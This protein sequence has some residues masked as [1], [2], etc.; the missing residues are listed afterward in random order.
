METGAAGREPVA[1]PARPIGAGGEAAAATRPTVAGIG[2]RSKPEGAARTDW[3]RRVLLSEHFVLYLTLV[4]FIALLPFLPALANP[5]N[6]S[7]TLSNVWPLLAVAV[8]QTFVLTIG[9]IDL[10]QGAVVGLTSVVAAMLLATTASPDVLAASPVWGTVITEEGG[11][12]AGHPYG[13]P[14]ALLAMFFTAVLIGLFNGVSVASFEM[15]PFMV[16]LVTLI[17]MGAFAI[18]IT[19]SENIRPLPDS[20]V[21]LG[22]GD[23]VSVYL[24]EKV[25][26]QIPRRQIFSFVTYPMV[27]AVALAVAAHLLLSRTVF[28][29]YVYA[30]GTNRR[31]AEISG[32]PVRRVI[33]AVF[34]VSAVCAAVG[35]LLYS[36]RLEAGRP[37]LGAGTF[38]LDVIGATVIGGT[39]LF[40]GKG[41]ILW[42]FFGVLFFVLLSNTLNLMNLSSFH[43][44]MVKGAVILA[45][46]LLDVTR[47]RF[48]MRAR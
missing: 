38:L 32:V 16:T 19:H 6:L 3:L 18:Y 1:D 26:P 48:L 41:K 20:Y 14:L 9:G 36:A 21:A 28:G 43:I 22:K 34:I 29:R 13:L 4:Y 30:I 40:G 42:T 39:S 47:T 7:N 25:E 15:P 46:A 11:L 31:A 12:L 44:D 5:A 37:T 8:G 45:A 24:G 27:I 33:I 35:G 2:A 10:S 23:I 17:A